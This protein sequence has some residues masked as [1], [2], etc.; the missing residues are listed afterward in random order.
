MKNKLYLETGPYGKKYHARLLSR[1]MPHVPQNFSLQVIFTVINEGDTHPFNFC[2]HEILFVLYLKCLSHTVY[3]ILVH[4][5]K[6]YN[7]PN[8]TYLS[9]IILSSEMILSASYLIALIE[10]IFNSVNSLEPH[11]HSWDY[12]AL[13]LR[14]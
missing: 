6:L 9:S 8:S 14:Y 1:K 2:M 5:C 10:V 7:K 4:S 3:L 12:Q 11:S 13:K